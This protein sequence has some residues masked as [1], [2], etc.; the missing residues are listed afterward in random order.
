M[1]KARSLNLETE[2]FTA[3][4]REG[5]PDYNKTAPRSFYFTMGA[6]NEGDGEKGTELVITCTEE[7]ASVLIRLLQQAKQDAGSDFVQ[8]VIPW[9]VGRWVKWVKKA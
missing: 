2:M 1:S 8:V 5:E 3:A 9:G 4:G 6:P 7:D